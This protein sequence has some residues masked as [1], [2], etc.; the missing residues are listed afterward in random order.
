MNVMCSGD[1]HCDRELHV[2]SSD[3]CLSDCGEDGVNKLEA[4]LWRQP[5]KCHVFECIAYK[6]KFVQILIVMFGSFSFS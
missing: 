4:R 5:R 2:N 1:K 6:S 3:G